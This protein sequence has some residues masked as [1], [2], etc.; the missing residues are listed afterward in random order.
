MAIPRLHLQWTVLL[1]LVAPAL[2]TFPVSAQQITY[3]NFNT[4]ANPANNPSQ[5]SYDCS[6]TPA[7]FCFNYQGSNQDPTFI[8][9]PAGGITYA[10]QMTYPVGSQAASMWFSVPQK[11]LSGF[12]VWFQIKITPARGSTPADGIAF[13]IQNATGGGTDPT[14]TCSETGEGPTVVGGGG[15]CIGY[16]GI[17][18][19]VALEF[20]TYN[21]GS[22]FGDPDNNHI[23]L[24]DCGAGKANSP[25]HSLC[26]VAGTLISNP[27][28]SGTGQPITLA[29]G[30]VHDVVIVY[31]GPNDIS[32][33]T[34]SVYIDPAYNPGTYTPT[35][36]STAVFTEPFNIAQAMNLLNSGSANDSAYVGFT[37]AT[38]AAFET[39]EIMAWTFTPH[40]TVSQTQPLNQP[41]DTEPATTTYDF[42]THSYSVTYPAGSE[43]QTAGV[44]MGV[45]ANTISQANFAALLGYGPSQYAGSLCQVYDDTGGNCIIYSVYC[46]QGSPS[47]VVACPKPYTG[48][49]PPTD[50]LTNSSETACIGL[51]SAYDN[52]VQPTSPGYLQ[53][54]P[55][56]SPITSIVGN[57]TTA[58]V[59]CAGDCSVSDGQTVNILV[60]GNE[61]LTEEFSNV[62][63]ISPSGTAPNTFTF[64]STFNGT[65][66][67]GFLTSSNVQDIFTGYSPQNIDGTT[68]GKTTN[69]G[70]D[71]VVTGTTVAGTQT[72][73]SAP[74]NNN[75][76]VQ[77]V[78]EELTA[79]V[80][81]SATEPAGLTLLSIENIPTTPA[82]TFTPL[83]GSTISGSVTFSDSNSGN[84]YVS[85]P[86]SG[87]ENVPLT[88]VTVSDVTTYQAQC[89]YTPPVTGTDTITA[90]Y[91]DNPNSPY[92]Q[93]SQT[94]L[95]LN[96]GPQTVPV[97]LATS[98][99]GLTYEVVGPSVLTSGTY[100]TSQTL[101]WDIGTNYT[102]IVPS[103]T[104]TLA[105]TPNTQYVFSQWSNGGTA[106]DM[107]TASTTT[108][109]YTAMF[110]TQYQL[111]ATAGAGGTVTATNGFYNA[112]S[113]EP[114][115]ATPNPGYTFSG[116]TGTGTNQVASLGGNNYSVT[117][118]GPAL[119]TANFTA[120]PI[121]GISPPSI[122]FGTLYL[123]SIVTKAVEITNTGAAPMTISDPR[124]AILPGNVIGNLSEFITL[125]L[126][127]KTLAAGKSC[128][129]T[130][131]FIAGPFYGQQNAALT[132]T[133]SAAGS[134]QTVQ[135][136]ANV[137]NPQASLSPSSLSF[138]TVSTGTAT[139]SK[140]VTLS[141]PGGT[142][143]SITG[144]ALSGTDQ[145]DYS[146][147]SDTCASSYAYSLPA[148]KNC[149]IAISF[150]PL[151]KGSLPASLVVTD[152]AKSGSQSVSLMGT[153]K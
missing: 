50:C 107:V 142:T 146:I 77:N 124:I 109:S 34:I 131:T 96:V 101:T 79:T 104:Q 5:Y 8:Q 128:V 26:E 103:T 55:L 18:N 90:Q 49:T 150:K 125:N 120:V 31:N 117:L 27:P 71:F 138:G 119:L 20:D 123:G 139:A 54:D 122:D 47:N 9:D 130:I 100:N 115:V 6:T 95:A 43:G 2:L 87:C 111:S 151:A 132:I 75:N 82:G 83:P 108:T 38:G 143:L 80:G 64:A 106:T 14:E 126:C 37:S 66:N 61:G 144:I 110:T 28:A 89:N 4:P 68:A 15:G 16:G 98:P 121:I 88:A 12:N 84:N 133:D 112:G 85:T 30:T 59:T 118:N 92:H 52:T 147:T 3:Y 153:G 62:S 29:D 102:L 137:I 19:S 51:Q 141:N 35:S 22:I 23:A 67:G 81:P 32:P 10:T 46:Y 149:T 129:M 94:T 25:D 39:N 48:D 42:G 78:A 135:L 53:G 21:N 72:Q 105:S 134:P 152:N 63:V 69:L 41:T 56:Y 1:A 113:M 13:V 97:M 60:Y 17:D 91:S 136:T 58:T 70:S 86:I 145:G 40:T 73:L 148:G 11:V 127:P 36:G 65:D 140:S 99:S 44:T 114:I 24:Q 116:W 57:G 93:Q 74:N 7:L 33:N 76:A 45:I